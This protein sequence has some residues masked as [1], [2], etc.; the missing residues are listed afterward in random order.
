MFKTDVKIYLLFKFALKN[1]NN[2]KYVSTHTCNTTPNMQKK[3]TIGKKI[4]REF[5]FHST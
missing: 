4:L 3:K 1:N 5:L 2:P